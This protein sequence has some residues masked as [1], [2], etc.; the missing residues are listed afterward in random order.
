MPLSGW[1]SLKILFK[2]E[3]GKNKQSSERT[4]TMK[5]TSLF[6]ITLAA[7]LPLTALAAENEARQKPTA[8]ISLAELKNQLSL[9]RGHV[10]TTLAALARVKTA[11]RDGGALEKAQA[12]FAGQL[13]ALE[14][15]VEITRTNAVLVK[16][17]TKDHYEHWQK[18]ISDVKNPQIREKA[19]ERFAEAREQFDKIIATAEETKQQLVPFIADLKD[20]ALYLQA[21]LSQDAVKSLSNTIW[22]L[23]NKS[24]S[25][26]GGI[27]DIIEQIDRTIKVMPKA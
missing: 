23:G 25:V 17:P 1:R 27:G 16:A 22:K 20:V 26:V 9:L 4:L 18:E 13:K 12:D 7:G 8:L 10:S 15:Q 11:G 21:D 24:K 14:A 5:L 2:H 6:V 19:E 3:M